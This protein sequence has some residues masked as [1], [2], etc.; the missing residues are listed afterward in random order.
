MRLLIA[1]DLG[2]MLAQTA[3]LLQCLH[4]YPNVFRRCLENDNRLCLCSFKAAGY[5]DLPKPGGWVQ[6]PQAAPGND[7]GE[8]PTT[9]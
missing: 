5:T 4:A 2:A 7:Q 3:D 9:T 6:T 8:C 1:A